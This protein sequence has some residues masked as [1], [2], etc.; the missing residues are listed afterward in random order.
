VSTER[1]LD[2]RGGLDGDKLF[3]QNACGLEDLL[4]HFKQTHEV[5][6]LLATSRLR[7]F[8]L[9]FH[10]DK[11]RRRRNQHIVTVHSLSAKITWLKHCRNLGHVK[12]TA[13]RGQL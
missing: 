12:L 9:G 3:L 13:A 6:S 8:P 2:A 11:I 10:L 4:V 5:H 7:F 1:G